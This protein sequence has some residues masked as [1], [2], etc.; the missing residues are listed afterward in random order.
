MK[1]T[2]HKLL[3]LCA[4]VVTIGLSMLLPGICM[5]DAQ[6]FSALDGRLNINGYARQSVSVN[7]SDTA[8]TSEDDRFDL[9]MVRSTLFLDS[10]LDMDWARFVVIGRADL[11]YQTDY[12]RRLD[13][14]STKD[15]MREYDEFDLRE[16]YMDLAFGNR[17]SARLGKQ[18]PT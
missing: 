11:E 13:D 3:L 12:L 1:K 2:N 10:S 6:A 8:E 14:L 15:I 18:I 5:N 16:Y 7:L 9:Q 4:G 17:V